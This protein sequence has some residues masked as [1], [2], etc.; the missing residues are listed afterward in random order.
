MKRKAIIAAM[1]V[2]LISGAA[3]PKAPDEDPPARATLG[4]QPYKIIDFPTAGLLPRA[5]FRVETDV[6]ADGGVLVSLGVGFTRYFSFGISY[7][8]SN[9]IGSDDP[10]MNPE[11]AVNL[12]ARIIE[13]SFV[14]PAVAIG[15][16]SQGYGEYLEDEGS[17]G[18]E[19]YLV[20]SRGI[21]AVASKNWDL[22]GPLSLH[23]GLGYSLE[24]EKDHDPTIFIGLIK[25]FGGVVDVCGEYDFATNDNEGNCE[26]IENRGYLNASFVW[27]VNENLSLSIEVRDIATK[28][29]TECDGI[30]IDDLREWNRGLSITYRDFL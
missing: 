20:K 18:E 12:K 13:E 11:P 10:E 24:D 30:E 25:S 26:I 16:D 7:G 23:G 6:Y 17:Y 15:F 19:R 14:F 22:L 2:L 5:G 9:L 4:A 3:Y 28:S 1:A 21:F 8:G 27:H 29:R